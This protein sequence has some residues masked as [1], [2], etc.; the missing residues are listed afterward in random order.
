VQQ[1]RDVTYLRLR[2]ADIEAVRRSRWAVTFNDGDVTAN[3]SN[4]STVPYALSSSASAAGGGVV[5]RSSSVTE[6]RDA[7][8]GREDGLGLRSDHIRFGFDARVR[9]LGIS[10]E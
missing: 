4:T 6:I 2:V 1:Q 8:V 5:D 9:Q 7:A 10:G 3:E